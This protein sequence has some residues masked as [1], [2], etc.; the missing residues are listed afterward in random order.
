MLVENCI[1][2][3]LKAVE[4]MIPIYE[5]QL[6]TYMRLSDVRLGFLLNFNVPHLREGIKRMVV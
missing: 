2:V 6:M 1:I 4:K 5:A 3:E